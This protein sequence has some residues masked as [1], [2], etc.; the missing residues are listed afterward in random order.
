MKPPLQPALGLPGQ[1][2]SLGVTSPWG[3]SYVVAVSWAPYTGHP[4]LTFLNLACDK[5]LYLPP[6]LFSPGTLTWTGTH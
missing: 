6:F 1:A 3:S 2:H 5:L 4:V